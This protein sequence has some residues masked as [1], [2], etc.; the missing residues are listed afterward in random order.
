MNETLEQSQVEVGRIRVNVRKVG[1]TVLW[2]VAAT[3]LAVGAVWVIREMGDIG[4][5][6][7][8][9]FVGVNPDGPVSPIEEGA[10]TLAEE[11]VQS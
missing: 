1:E 2:L 7:D 6:F 4:P 10:H 9:P 3:G 11:S 8:N 5:L